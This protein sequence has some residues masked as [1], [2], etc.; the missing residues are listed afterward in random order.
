MQFNRVPSTNVITLS[1]GVSRG[2]HILTEDRQM[3]TTEND[4]EG[5]I[6]EDGFSSA[7]F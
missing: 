4:N 3:I 7:N 1:I 2:T 6:V 5:L